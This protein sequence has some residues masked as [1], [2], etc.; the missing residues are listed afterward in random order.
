MCI[1]SEPFVG[2]P[3]LR[4]VFVPHKI[5]KVRIGLGRLILGD[6]ALRLRRY[7]G[8]GHLAQ[9]GA[10]LGN[11][12]VADLRCLNLVIIGLIFR[13]SEESGFKGGR[14]HKVKHNLQHIFC[15]VLPGLYHL[16]R[17]GAHLRGSSPIDIPAAAIP[18]LRQAHCAEDVVSVHAGRRVG[19][20][21]LHVRTDGLGFDLLIMDEGLAG[22][23]RLVFAPLFVQLGLI[24]AGDRDIVVKGVKPGV[25]FRTIPDDL[26]VVVQMIRNGKQVRCSAQFVRKGVNVKIKALA[27]GIGIPARLARGRKELLHFPVKDDPERSGAA[28]VHASDLHADLHAHVFGI[29]LHYFNMC[30]IHVPDPDPAGLFGHEYGPALF[31]VNAQLP[32]KPFPAQIHT[33]DGIKPETVQDLFHILIFAHEW[34]APGGGECSDDADNPPGHRVCFPQPIGHLN[35]PALIHHG[36][37]AGRGAGKPPPAHIVERQRH[38]RGQL[39]FH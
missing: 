22:F 18:V 38:G 26:L 13:D 35:G 19:I 25:F 1:I 17:R 31:P 2:H 39:F 30:G 27:V 3:F 11:V 8:L 12:F 34:H 36:Q 14:D 33:V 29:R 4:R 10:E 15:G 7:Q 20:K 23:G 6:P 24:R 37:L 5:Q 32:D 21:A 9:H 16:E 28:S